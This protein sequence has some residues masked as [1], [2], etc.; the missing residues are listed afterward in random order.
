MHGKDGFTDEDGL[1]GPLRNDILKEDE[2]IVIS[3]LE[4]R[5]MTALK[6]K[7]CGERE[8]RHG[9]SEENFMKEKGKMTH[10]TYTLDR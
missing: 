1:S 8:G 10:S 6:V 2:E 3:K 4:Q 7:T 9:N 5:S